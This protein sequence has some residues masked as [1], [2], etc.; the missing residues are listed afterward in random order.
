MTFVDTCQTDHLFKRLLPGDEPVE[1]YVGYPLPGVRDLPRS[2][3]CS[4]GGIPREP[5]EEKP[6]VGVWTIEQPTDPISLEVSGLVDP[7]N[8]DVTLPFIMEGKSCSRTMLKST[9]GFP[10]P[11]EG[12]NG[13]RAMLRP[14]FGIPFC[15]CGFLASLPFVILAVAKLYRPL[16][17]DGW[18]PERLQGF[19]S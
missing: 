3:Y 16:L 2:F 5:Q 13:A 17:A 15:L 18:V 7:A 6:E 19:D 14:V 10:L 12:G 8:P 9:C 11:E 1:A 4:A